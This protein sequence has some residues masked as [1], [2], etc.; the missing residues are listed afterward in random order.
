M[1]KRAFVV[2]AVVC[3]GVSSGAETNEEL[4]EQVRKAETAFAKTMA[5]R[6]HAAFVSF[7]AEDTIFLGRDEMHGKKAVGDAW[8]GFYEGKDAPFS[9]RPER[10][11]VLPAG[12]LAL[13]TGPVFAPDGRQMG[14]YN[15]T[16][17]R[18][19]DGS[20]KIV[21]DNGC[22]CRPICETAAAAKAAVPAPSPSPR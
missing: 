20:W 12:N 10:V 2:M 17:R 5:D 6:D 22:N 16:W 7:L 19:K 1:L 15:S 14:Q 9:W 21:F 11:V 13:S 4:R 8:K 3:A 18:E